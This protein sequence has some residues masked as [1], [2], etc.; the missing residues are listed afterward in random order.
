MSRNPP[1]LS[2][3]RVPPK[4]DNLPGLTERFV[5][6]GDKFHLITSQNCDDVL[7]AVKA[8]RHTVRRGKDQHY[9]GSVPVLVAQVWAN[10]CKAPLGTREFLEYAGKKIKSPEFAHLQANLERAT[11]YTGS[12]P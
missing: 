9:L 7:A 2:T 5:D 12:K 3:V 6:D 10:E 11:F 8:A 1:S 4:Y